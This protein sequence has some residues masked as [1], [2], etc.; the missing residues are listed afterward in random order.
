MPGYVID[1]QGNKTVA[2]QT[3]PHKKG[4]RA[5]LSNG[6]PANTRKLPEK[7]VTGNATKKVAVK[8]ANPEKEQ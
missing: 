1:E 8:K 4:N 2:N 7:K 3:T 5:R 6:E